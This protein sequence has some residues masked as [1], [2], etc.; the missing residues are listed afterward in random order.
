MLSFAMRVQR[1][2]SFLAIH[3]LTWSCG[4]RMPVAWCRW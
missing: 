3:S 2:G 4:T 1:K